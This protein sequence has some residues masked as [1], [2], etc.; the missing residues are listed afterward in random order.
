MSYDCD[1]CD[2]AIKLKSK[3]NNFKSL[4]HR[5]NENFIRINYT[6]RNPD[7]FDIDKVYDD[8]ITNQNKK[9]EIYCVELDF[10]EKFTY[11]IEVLIKT[12]K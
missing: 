4:T 6:I 3:N 1:I 2:E 8:Y 11:N 5:E 7:F 10:K 9:F 12:D